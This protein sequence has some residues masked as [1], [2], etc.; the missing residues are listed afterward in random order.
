M[1][2]HN[3]VGKQGE[4]AAVRYLAKNGYD[5]IVQ[6]WHFQKAEIDIIAKYKGQIIIV[7]VKTRTSFEFENPKEA[8][9]IPKQKRIVRAADAFIQEQNIDLECRFDIVSVLIQGKKMDIEHIEDAFGP[10]L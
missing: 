2:D 5:I 8:V 3:E 4:V 1:A 7:E 6:N 9:T 10:M